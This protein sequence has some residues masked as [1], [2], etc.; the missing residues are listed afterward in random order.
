MECGPLVI[1]MENWAALLIPN[2][3]ADD[4]RF[5]LEVDPEHVVV[6]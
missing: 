1:G 4:V 6:R 5:I 3:V 2:E